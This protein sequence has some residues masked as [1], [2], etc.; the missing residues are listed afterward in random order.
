M[1]KYLAS[2]S[3]TSEGVA[4]LLKIGGTRRAEE[5]GR[6]ASGLGGKLEAMYFGLDEDDSYVIFD[7]PDNITAGALAKAVNAAGTS[8]CNMKPLLTP[9]EVDELVKID[10][11][12][13]PPGG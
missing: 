8:H 11:K 1:P 2:G 10:T 13:L 7:L 5:I 3:Y 6:I 9:S 12:F 4:G